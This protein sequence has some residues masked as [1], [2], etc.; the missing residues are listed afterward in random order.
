MTVL[1]VE[2]PGPARAG[3]AVSRH[4]TTAVRRNRVRRRLREAYRLTRE[5]QPDG[6]AVVI[7]GKPSALDAAFAALVAEL[8]E[9]L[10]ALSRSL[11]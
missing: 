3:F 10:G 6:T 8:R 11:R 9:A 4:V 5:A 7:I 2:A 1:W